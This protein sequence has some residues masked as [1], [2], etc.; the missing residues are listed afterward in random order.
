M[1]RAAAWLFILAVVVG[2]AVVLDDWRPFADRARDDFNPCLE[3]LRWRVGPVDPGFDISREE[4]RRTVEAAAAVWESAT[5]RRFFEH[6]ATDG[7]PVELVYDRRQATADEDRDRRRRLDML[8]VEIERRQRT[9]RRRRREYRRARADHERRMAEI[10]EAIRSH[11]ETVERWNARG[12]APAS[13]LR[14][15]RERAAEIERRRARADRL[16]DSLEARRRRLESEA[17]RI[18]QA[19]AEFDALAREH[20][21]APSGRVRSGSFEETVITRGGR[22]SRTDRKVTIYQFDGRGE[23]L[24]VL[25]HELG[26]ALGLAHVAEPGAIMHEEYDRED[27]DRPLRL[28][29][30]DFTALI[31]RCGPDVWRATR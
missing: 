16:A 3:P 13:V 28:R 2:G 23:L 14:R 1:N 5:G 19:I 11:N 24:R 20:Q 21:R 30:G 31:D 4:V 27:V 17:E 12:G 25:A 15:L 10:G 7:W 29:D 6:D 18:Q 8:D 9:H 26:H 22:R